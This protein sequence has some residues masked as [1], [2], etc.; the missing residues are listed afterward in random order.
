MFKRKQYQ[1]LTP[2]REARLAE[3]RSRSRRYL[4]I[5]GG[6]A[7]GVLF[8]GLLTYLLQEEPP[9]SEDYRGSVDVS[10]QD[11]RYS[12]HLPLDYDR[13]RAYP[14]LIAYHGRTQSAV[15]F[16][17]MSA[18]DA[19]ANDEGFIVVYPEGFLRMWEV[20]DVDQTQVDDLAFFDA[21]LGQLRREISYD[22]RRV[23]AAGFSQGG[24]FS[25]R[26]ACERSDTL[27]AVASVA[28][29]MTPELVAVC[30]PE[31]PVP[32]IVIHGVDD[33]NIPYDE[34]PHPEIAL[35][36]PDVLALW[37]TIDGCGSVVS[38]PLP[39]SADDGATTEQFTYTG[40]DA[41]VLAY[42]VAGGGHTWP[43]APIEDTEM[44]RITTRDF[45]ASQVIWDFFADQ[46][47]TP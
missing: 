38:D 13:R 32:L 27:A 28:G 40:C 24:F 6:V 16:R 34:G 11:R 15:D 22:P 30:Q 20:D 17:A 37:G 45:S 47:L 1:V 7:V 39:D 19:V 18:F 14:L 46:S 12:V 21:L 3:G 4:L 36:V 8:V 10:G 41:P 29:S 44:T 23:Y 2:A 26:L 5:A 25:Y 35:D 43:G 9:P 31:H 33:N 42:V